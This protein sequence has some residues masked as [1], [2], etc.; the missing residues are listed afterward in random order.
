M[1]SSL[2]CN[3][4]AAW[5]QHVLPGIAFFCS[6]GRNDESAR[7][8][9]LTDFD[10]FFRETFAP[11]YALRFI[12]NSLSGLNPAENAQDFP[13]DHWKHPLA[14]QSGEVRG[15]YWPRKRIILAAIPAGVTW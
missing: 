15:T 1:A 2:T 6:P 4:L 14:K 7:V 12:T 9:R 11:S 10:A 13:I 5:Y 8:T 3:K